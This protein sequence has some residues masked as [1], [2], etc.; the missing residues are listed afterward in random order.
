MTAERARQ[1]AKERLRERWGVDLD[2]EQWEAIVDNA[3]KDLYERAQ[4]TITN[5]GHICALVP[6]GNPDSKV[7]YVP[8]VVNLKHGFVLTV[9]PPD[10]Q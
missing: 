9:L 1:H 3:R 2:D 8:M 10:D 5:P 6:M 7:H 4:S